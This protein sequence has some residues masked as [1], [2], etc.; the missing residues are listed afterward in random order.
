MALSNLTGRQRDVFHG[1]FAQAG[2][3]VAVPKRKVGRVAGTAH[4]PMLKSLDSFDFDVQPSLDRKVVKHLETL[5]FVDR[6]ENVV[7]L[8]PPDPATLCTS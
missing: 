8:G 2:I 4:L 3:R 6:A 7:L 5:A 1:L